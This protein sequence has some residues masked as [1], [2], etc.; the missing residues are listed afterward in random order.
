MNMMTFQPAL[1]VNTGLLQIYGHVFKKET[2]LKGPKKRYRF[3]E[4]FQ[5]GDMLECHLAQRF[6]VETLP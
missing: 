1:L 2:A 5:L 6:W 4:E 3:P